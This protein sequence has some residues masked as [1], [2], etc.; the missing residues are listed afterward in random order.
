[1]IF[2]KQQFLLAAMPPK[3]ETQH[4]LELCLLCRGCTPR[5]ALFVTVTGQIS[6]AVRPGTLEEGRLSHCCGPAC[7]IVMQGASVRL[8]SA[9]GLS[10][11]CKSLLGKPLGKLWVE[12]CHHMQAGPLNNEPPAAW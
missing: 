4:R 10:T 9:V 1:V 5:T 2:N 11:L 3:Q 12:H 6:A 8:L 7:C